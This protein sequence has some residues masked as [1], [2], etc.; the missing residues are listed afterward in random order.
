MYAQSHEGIQCYLRPLH[1][2]SLSHVV[3]AI[4]GI[5]MR[6]GRDSNIGYKDTGL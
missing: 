5:G 4:S 6:K 1:N 2:E 3:R